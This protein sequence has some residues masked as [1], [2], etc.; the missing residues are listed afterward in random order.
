M[1][2]QIHAQST[3]N[4]ARAFQYK[5]LIYLYSDHTCEAPGCKTVLVLDGNMK[6][7]R[8]VCMVKDIGELHFSNMVGS[9]LVG[10]Y[11][12]YKLFIIHIVIR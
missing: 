6:N 2:K 9:I 1:K 11:H 8:Q 5:D 4:F 7:A 12:D 10:K 3:T